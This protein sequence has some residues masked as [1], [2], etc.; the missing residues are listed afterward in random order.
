MDNLT[1]GRKKILVVDDIEANRAIVAEMFKDKYDILEADDGKLAANL[2]EHNLGSVVIV[3]LDIIMPKMDGFAFLEFLKIK[4]LSDKI[5]VILITS[6]IS[7][8][9]EEKGYDFNIFDIVY[10]PFTPNILMSRVENAIR[11]FESKNELERRVDRQTGRYNANIGFVL[12][13]LGSIVEFRSRESGAHVNRQLTKKLLEYV[14]RRHPEYGLTEDAMEDISYAASIYDIGKVAISD[15]ILL[16]AGRLTPDEFS[17]VKTHTILGCDIL[18]KFHTESIGEDFFR[19]CYDVCRSHHERW[20]GSGY[21]DGLMRDEIPIGAQVVSIVDAYNGLANVRCY[22]DS[23]PHVEAVR[24]IMDGECG[25][26]SP[27]LLECFRLAEQDFYEIQM[28][29]V[30][31]TF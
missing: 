28:K 3:L 23:Y 29:H 1:G 12:D 6:D 14:A 25:V 24:M 19:C 26:F 8:E 22:K 9:S 21:P 17:V 15:A 18:N 7:L 27:K 20:D 2:L 30:A 13:V 31:Y 5:P 10:K 16:K 4:D 11:I